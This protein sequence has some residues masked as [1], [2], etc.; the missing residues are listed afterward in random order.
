MKAMLSQ[1]MNGKT[2][3]EIVAT[4]EKAI[5]ALETQGYELVD[6]YFNDE[7]SQKENMEAEFG[8][9]TENDNT[10]NVD[11]AQKADGRGTAVGN[12]RDGHG[13]ELERAARNAGQ[14]VPAA[15]AVGHRSEKQQVG[16]RPAD[17]EGAV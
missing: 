7:W 16:R 6:T 14:A 10:R 15:D 8:Y 1:P 12:Q 13:A 5:K 17:A 4:R 2:E 3:E 11:A 9:R